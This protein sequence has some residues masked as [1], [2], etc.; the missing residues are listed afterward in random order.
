MLMPRI[1]PLA[2]DMVASGFGHVAFY[3]AQIYGAA[4]LLAPGHAYL[5]PQNVGRFGIANVI[6]EAARNLRF[7]RNNIDQITVFALIL[8]GIGLLFAQIGLLGFAVFVQTASAAMPTTWAGFFVTADPTNDIA[9]ILMDRVF[10]IPNF[11]DSCVNQGIPC[12]NATAVVDGAIP[13]PYHTALQSML[14][15]YSVGLAV[16]GLIIFLYYIVAIAVETA[17][18]GTPFGRRYNHVWAPIR[19]VVALALLIPLSYGLN[20]AQFLTLYMAKWGSSFA[21]NGWTLFS[22]VLINANVAMTGNQPDTMVAEPQKPKPNDLFRFYTV[23]AT[24]KQAYALQGITIDAYLVQP[25]QIP[26]LPNTLMEGQSWQQAIDWYEK[27]AILVVFG[28]PGHPDFTGDVKPY[29]GEITLEP[30]D[31]AE[32]GS[33]TMQT[34]YY[35]QLIQAPWDNIKNG[36]ILQAAAALPP[37][38]GAQQDFFDNAAKNIIDVTLLPN[39]GNSL[40]PDIAAQNAIMSWWDARITTIIAAGIADQIASPDW[41]GGLPGLGWAGAG[42]WYNKIAQ[43]NGAISAAVANLPSVRSWPLVMEDVAEEKAKKD[44]NILPEHVYQPYLSDGSPVQLKQPEDWPLARTF[45]EAY[46]LW[47]ASYLS[48]MTGT[49][50]TNIHPSKNAFVS[51]VNFLFGTQGLYSMRYNDGNNIH[52]LAQIVVMGKNL[53]DTAIRNLA[54]G[55][56]GTLGSIIAPGDAPPIIMKALASFAWSIGL[57]TLSMGFVMYYVIPFLPFIYFFFQVGGWIKALFEA[58]V[59]LPLWALAHIRID[60]HGLPGSAA[61]NGYFLIF[62]IFLRPV[63][64]IFGFVGGIAIFAAQV[65]ILNEI[66]DLVVSNVTGFDHEA[67]K[68][69]AAGD[70]GSFQYARGGV[71]Q[72]FHTVI[73]AI[74][75]YMMAVSSFKLVY[76][77]P[78]NMLRWMNSGVDGFAETAMDAPEGIVSKAYG[79][80]SLVTNQIS[81]ATSVLLGMGGKK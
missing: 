19:M 40:L 31:Q 64:T 71:D 27:G 75:V 74:I 56:G 17:Q 66:F 15:F 8:M 46:N 13:F 69:L 52:P 61:L 60:G 41:L 23:L 37:P 63:L 25:V 20:G 49:G 32:P 28:E 30:T 54:I 80:S 16:I 2:K 7:T 22:D 45:Y 62:E 81:G 78:N 4:R 67:A 53:F 70:V 51:I 73:Y 44:K 59:G 3:I 29:C 77:V 65:Q 6:L 12:I 34:S 48:E 68:A 39:T 50:P 35:E 58:M 26:L 11:F 42:I 72:L 47:S 33:V 24:C 14:G 79:G 36:T 21:T 18:T 5:S 55:V 76:L 38:S 10:G 9:Y 57:M 1:I 43:M